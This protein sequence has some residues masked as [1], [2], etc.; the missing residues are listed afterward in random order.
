MGRGSQGRF[1]LTFL[2]N[3]L[4]LNYKPHITG[5]EVPLGRTHVLI[6][7]LELALIWAVYT[8]AAHIMAREM[9]LWATSLIIIA[10]DRT[11]GA[12]TTVASNMRTPKT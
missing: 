4:I 9:P 1:S 12:I 7:I 6:L 10:I 3:S 8:F 11:I 2:L 5:K